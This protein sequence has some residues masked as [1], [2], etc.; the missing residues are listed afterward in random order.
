MENGC[1]KRNVFCSREKISHLHF[2]FSPKP[3]KGRERLAHIAE[4]ANTNLLIL[5]TGK[6][7]WH[8]QFLKLPAQLLRSI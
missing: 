2:L 8:F 1:N 5:E 3:W 7:G 6:L 4:A